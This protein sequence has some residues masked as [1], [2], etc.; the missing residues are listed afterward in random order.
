V[1]SL[2][3]WWFGI[4]VVVGVVLWLVV[5]VVAAVAVL[6]A[7]SEHVG[8]AIFMVLSWIALIAFA[9][10]SRVLEWIGRPR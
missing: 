4:F 7:P 5:T 8:L 3:P 10:M 9:G 1:D 6:Q 2:K